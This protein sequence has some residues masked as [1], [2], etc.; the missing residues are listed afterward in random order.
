MKASENP[1]EG[2]QADELFHCEIFNKTPRRIAIPSKQPRDDG[3]REYLLVSP[4]STKVL[5]RETLSEYDCDRWEREDLVEVR[6]E[7]VA[8]MT[9]ESDT[10]LISLGLGFWLM[11]YYIVARLVPHPDE[12]PM[13]LLRWQVFAALLFCYLIA[14]VVS[15]MKQLRIKRGFWSDIKYWKTLFMRGGRCIVRCLNLTLFL[16]VVFGLGVGLFYMFS[17]GREWV[18]DPDY[19]KVIPLEYLGRV[20]QYIFITISTL[21]PA[22]MYFLFNRR[23]REKVQDTFIREVLRLDPGIRTIS[24]AES[25][26]LTLVQESFGTRYSSAFLLR[27]GLPILLCSLLILICWLL[28]LQPFGDLNVENIRNMENLLMPRISAVTFAF[29]GSYFYAISLVFRCYIR[30]DLSPKTYTHVILR[31]FLA[32]I[33]AWTLSALPMFSDQQGLLYIFAF[34]VG[35][36]PE[37][38]LTVLK[39]MARNPIIERWFPRLEEEHPLTKLDGINL[40]DR[41]R[42]LEEGIENVENLAHHNLISLM[43]STRISTNR[44]VDLFDQAILYLHLGQSADEVDKA[45]TKLRAYG[46]RTATDLIAGYEAAESRDIAGKNGTN[47]HLNQFL[48]ILKRENDPED[49]PSRIQ[50]II[51][52]LSDDDWMAY[53]RNWRQLSQNPNRCFTLRGVLLVPMEPKE[54]ET[55]TGENM[56]EAI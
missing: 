15:V 54:L 37:T 28:V 34:F 43:L 23:Q 31:L 7:K 4:F 35:I 25:K 20:I 41:S 48:M 33:L 9:T 26:Y 12:S 51:D 40:F 22:L 49:A 5:S 10:A 21:L 38:G 45:R 19:P 2:V 17:G 39:D 36:L 44:L 55:E 3:K 11:V 29:L 13:K 47:D 18:E 53:L 32:I 27:S 24:E 52:T 14:I 42:F 1:R 16:G 30:S 46:I 8:S 56:M 6:E 50:V